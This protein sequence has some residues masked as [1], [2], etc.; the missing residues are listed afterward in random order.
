[1]FYLLFGACALFDSGEIATTCEDL[2]TC[3]GEE[4]VIV[5]TAVIDSGTEDTSIPDT[6]LD[7]AT[8]PE[9]SYLSPTHFSIA[10]NF[11]VGGGQILPFEENDGVYFMLSI[12]ENT[13]YFDPA[14]VVCILG[15]HTQNLVE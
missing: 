8:E 15:I 9:P 2:S 4:S 3:E 13:V 10:A 6:G 1:M 5:D 11:R 14:D 7:T 12:E